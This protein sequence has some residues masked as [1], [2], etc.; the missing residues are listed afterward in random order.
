MCCGNAKYKAPPTPNLSAAY[1]NEQQLAN[2]WANPSAGLSSQIY[3]QYAPQY[4]QTNADIYGKTAPQYAQT[5]ADIYGRTAPQYAQDNANIYTQTA[6]QYLAANNAMLEGLRTISPQQQDLADQSARSGM[7]A[8][9]NINGDTNVGQEVMNRSDYINS[10]LNQK[11]GQLGGIGGA[12]G[13]AALS[14]SGAGS[15]LSNSGGNSALGNSGATNAVGT[16]F[17]NP[18]SGSLGQQGALSLYQ[19]QTQNA[20]NQYQSAQANNPFTQ[21]MSVLGGIAKIAGPIAAMV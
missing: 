8:R 17:F 18:N 14:N 15:A 20:Q 9:G 13:G 7:A 12:G 3:N 6:P 2:S 16:N 4:A 1:N 5:N 21:A 19:G 11:L 10:L